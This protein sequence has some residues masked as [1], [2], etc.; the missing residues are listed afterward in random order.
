[1]YNFTVHI[2]IVQ[3]YLIQ[4]S[5]S[6]YFY[7]KISNTILSLILVL[8]LAVKSEYNFGHVLVL[9][10]EWSA[11]LSE[12]GDEAHLIDVALDYVIGPQEG[13]SI[14]ATERRNGGNSSVII[15]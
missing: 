4:I 10:N 9:G 8:N 2:K 15:N 1:M 6:F 7:I 5:Y 12:N 11:A 14:C 13:Y 3:T